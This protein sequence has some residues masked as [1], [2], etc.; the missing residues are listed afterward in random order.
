MIVESLVFHDTTALL[1]KMSQLLVDLGE[2]KTSAQNEF[3]TNEIVLVGMED[4]LYQRTK[5]I[6]HTCDPHV[7]QQVLGVNVMLQCSLCQVT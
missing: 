2:D 3:E 4:C 1:Q 5:L 6:W 7:T